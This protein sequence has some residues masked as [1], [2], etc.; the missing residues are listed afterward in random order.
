[1]NLQSDIKLQ[2]KKID[3]FVIIE[4]ALCAIIILSTLL[5]KYGIASNA[6][7][8]SF[9]VLIIGFVFH[10]LKLSSSCNLAI[11][12]L[13]IFFSG[14]SVIE[15]TIIFNKSLSFQYLKEYFIFI[16]TLL[17]M[18]LWSNTKINN[19]TIQFV[20]KF[21]IGI[22][23]LYPI[24][25]KFFPR[26]GAFNDLS[27]NF[28]NPNLTGM[29]ILQSLLY[30]ALGFLNLQKRFWKFVCVALFII[31]FYLLN[32]TG[33][34]NCMLSLLLFAVMIVWLLI[35]RSNKF[36]KFILIFVNI[37]PICFVPIYL[38]FINSVIEK[39]WLSF[40]ISEGKPLD[41]RV[42]IWTRILKT[43]KGY[44]LTGK[45]P[46]IA[47]NLHNSHLVLLASYG[48]VVL[49][50]VIIIT[51]YISVR[52][53][54]EITSKKQ[55]YAL[56]AFFACLF[57]GFGEGALFS[58]GQGIYIMVCGFLLL[59][60]ADCNENEQI[61]LQSINKKRTESGAYS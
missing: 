33:A 51:Y 13:A 7:T 31:N 24:A 54:N 40:L 52:V 37:A 18:F 44:W 3:L 55:E 23:A 25:Y 5:M 38:C 11:I 48:L 34:R 50:L 61:K 12:L 58:G 9:L 42:A 16:A 2:N 8:V 1:M 22:S 15:T 35:K 20:L 57:M 59:A 29:W 30:L 32:L 14:F 36:P 45:Y 43:L 47:G 21:N 10:T 27:L 39:G 46:E 41:S 17:L 6:F 28:S 19:K 56:A 4:F 53:N 49:F 60:R 26:E